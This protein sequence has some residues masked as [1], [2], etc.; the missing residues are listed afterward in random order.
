MR[1][2]SHKSTYKTK[3]LLALPACGDWATESITKSTVFASLA[4][5]TLTFSWN[6]AK[7][8]KAIRGASFTITH[9]IGSWRTS[10]ALTA[11]TPS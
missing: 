6:L 4:Q 11:V 2:R 7:Q 9:A 5:S 3:S 1:E 8:T 10:R